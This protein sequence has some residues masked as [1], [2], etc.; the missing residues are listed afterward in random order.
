MTGSTLKKNWSIWQIQDSLGK[1]QVGMKVNGQTQSLSFSYKG[2][3][4]SL[5]TAA[6]SNTPILF[7]SQ[8]HKI[9]IGV[10][11]RSVTLFIDCKRIESLPIKPRGK[12]DVDGFAVLG[13]LT[14]NPQV[15]V[16]VSTKII[17]LRMLKKL[18]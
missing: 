17:H 1:E 7:D 2:V 8:W 13:K 5:Q 12:I 16:P 15:S 6:F 11:R 4:G 14:D 18:V 9:M 3:D 10:E